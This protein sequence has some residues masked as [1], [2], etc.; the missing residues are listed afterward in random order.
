[1]RDAGGPDVLTAVDEVETE[2]AA[3]CDACGADN[4]PGERLTCRVCGEAVLSDGWVP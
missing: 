2:L 1:M 4:P 3:R